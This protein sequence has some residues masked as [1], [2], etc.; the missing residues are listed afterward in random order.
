MKRNGYWDFLC[1]LYESGRAKRD[2]E[3]KKAQTRDGGANI[4]FSR[5]LDQNQLSMRY[6]GYDDVRNVRANRGENNS[7]RKESIGI[8]GFG[9]TATVLSANSGSLRAL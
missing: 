4:P 1:F 2:A 3:M 6:A 7:R 5:I 8:S 9:L